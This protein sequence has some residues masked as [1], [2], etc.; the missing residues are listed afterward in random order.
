MNKEFTT[1]PNAPITEAVL[2]IRVELPEKVKLEDLEAY[3]A[4]IS[5]RF[6]EK[7]ERISFAGG[8]QISKDGYSTI[9][10]EH[11]INGYLFKS[12]ADKKIVQPSLGGFSFNKLNP[13]DSWESFCKEGRE[14]WDL[15]SQKY[16]PTKITRIAL[17]YINRIEIPLP[18]KEFEEYILTFPQ[19][20]PKLPQG[21]ANFIMQLV[22][23]NAEIEASAM[24]TL[25][26]EEIKD[27]NLPLIFDIDV[28]RNSVYVDDKE[29]IWSDFENLRVFKNEIFF[30]SITDKTKELFE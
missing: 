4:D 5:E 1:F 10:P 29:K 9:A 20:A 30:N 21:I 2:D 14:L 24:I 13:Y 11:K 19:I 18:M 15:Y 25:A 6:P 27:K 3:Q 12:Q 7:K 16:K 28:S 17:R 26:M 22:I 23:P 8:F